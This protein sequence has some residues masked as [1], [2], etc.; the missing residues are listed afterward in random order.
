MARTPLIDAPLD[1]MR[2]AERTV[3]DLTPEVVDRA[4]LDFYE[5]NQE[6]VDVLRAVVPISGVVYEPCNG[7]G[8]IS[9]GFP[10]CRVITND[11]DTAKPA[12]SHVD[13]ATYLYREPGTVVTNPPFSGAFEILA[14]ARTQGLPCAFLLRLSF[15]EPTLERGEWLAKH[16]PDGSITCPRP[17]FSRDGNSDS[18]TV[19]WFLWGIKIVPAIQVALTPSWWARREAKEAARARKLEREGKARAR[20]ARADLTGSSGG[21]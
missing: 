21:R 13:A 4:D 19:A 5:T 7:L 20:T 12:D 14:N 10:D 15:Q 18:V 16:P 6:L 2:A 11:I 3:R 9:R 17:S 1:V 8:A